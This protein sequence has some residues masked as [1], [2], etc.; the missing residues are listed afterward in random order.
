M[1]SDPHFLAAALPGALIA[2]ISKGGFGSGAAFV[3][4]PLMALVVEPGVALAVMLPVLM[5]VDASVLRPYWGRWSAPEARLLILG[6]LPGVALAAALWRVAPADLFRL[7]IGAVAL[8]FVAWRLRGRVPVRRPDRPP[9]GTAT[10]LAVG[11]VAGFTSFVS[12]AGG[13][14]LAVY[15]LAR[16]LPKTGYQATTVLVFWA[17]NIAKAAAFATLGLFTAQTLAAS[18]ALAPVAVLGALL[19]VRAHRLVPERA[20]FAVTYVLLTAAGA[21]LIWDALA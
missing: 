17:V 9:P 10:G 20:F 16:G 18:A 2:G 13:P 8:G 6:G 4:V 21:K 14:P 12:H 7:L 19:G 3:A 1:W 15:L 11:A 5:L